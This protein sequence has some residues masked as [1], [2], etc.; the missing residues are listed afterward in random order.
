MIRWVV[1]G[2]IICFLNF[3]IMSYSGHANQN[4]KKDVRLGYS[5]LISHACAFCFLSIY[6][7]RGSKFSKRIHA[8]AFDLPPSRPLRLG[9]A[10][11]LLLLLHLELIHDDL[12]GNLIWVCSL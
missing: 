5:F 2:S 1:L 4:N 3:R 11:V 8:K 6:H 10:F 7:H 9:K 12:L